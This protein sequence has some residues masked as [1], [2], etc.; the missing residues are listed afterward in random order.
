MSVYEQFRSRRI[1]RR[2]H[3]PTTIRLHLSNLPQSRVA[4]AHQNNIHRAYQLG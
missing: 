4:Q 1:N 2:I 3:H